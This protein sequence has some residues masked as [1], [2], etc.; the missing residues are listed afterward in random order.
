ML[1]GSID[2]TDVASVNRAAPAAVSHVDLPVTVD[3][4]DRAAAVSQFGHAAPTSVVPTSSSGSGGAVSATFIE[5]DPNTFADNFSAQ[6]EGITPRQ[7]W[8]EKCDQ[9]T[10]QHAP[11]PNVAAPS[12]MLI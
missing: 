5:R 11:A 7:F 10:A 1:Q 4:Y 6:D 3:V 9:N 12:P 2:A 8:V